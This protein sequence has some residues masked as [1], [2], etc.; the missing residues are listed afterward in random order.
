MKIHASKGDDAKDRYIE[1][2]NDVRN[3]DAG[4]GGACPEE[5][6]VTGRAFVP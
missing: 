1:Y 6:I 3:S 4:S 5:D 2:G